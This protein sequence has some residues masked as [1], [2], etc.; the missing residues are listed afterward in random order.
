MTTKSLLP[1]IVA[2]LATIVFAVGCQEPTGDAG[3]EKGHAHG[4]H[5][6]DHDHANCDH[7]HGDHD[8]GDHDHDHASHEG[9][10]HPPHGPN[11]GHIFNFDSDEFKGEWCQYKDNDVICV[12]LLDGKG[13]SQKPLVVE[14]FLIKPTVGSEDEPFELEPE[15][16]DP[17]GAAHK[18]SLDDKNL[19]I[20]I[21]L[22]VE[23][24]VITEGKTLKGEI[25][26]HEPMDH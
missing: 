3:G 4:E 14:Q 25:K 1:F 23:I 20:A 11:H 26:A 21:P 18:F 10:D 12:Y 15:D 7:D 5:G 19:R 8:H 2:M 16:V 9:H 24:E 13:E 17:E 22:G 6:D